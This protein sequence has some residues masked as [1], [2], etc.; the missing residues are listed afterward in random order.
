MSLVQ[1]NLIDTFDEWRIKTNTIATT[2]GDLAT[3]TTTDQTSLVNAINE[4]EAIS[5][6]N[7]E[8]IV[9]DLYLYQEFPRL[10]SCHTQHTVEL[11]HCFR[12]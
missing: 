11:G 12:V 9:E 3:L 6:N 8:H 7:L 5:T 1:V 4:I 10:S 2:G